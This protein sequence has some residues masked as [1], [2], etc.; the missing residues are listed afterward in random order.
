MKQLKYLI[1]VLLFLII[2]I[3][4]AWALPN[5]VGPWSTTNWD[6]CIGTYTLDNGNKHVGNFRNGKPHGQGTRTYASGSKY[7][8]EYKNGKKDGQGTL[9]WTDGVK[10]LSL[11]HIS[12][13][14]RP[15]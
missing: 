7:V 1:S 6:N 14:T 8:G 13:P 11:I 12:E 2:G 5:C 4:H 3:S 10:Y 9:T 15:Y